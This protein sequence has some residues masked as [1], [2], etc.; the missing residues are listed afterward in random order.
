MDYLIKIVLF[1]FQ[2]ADSN[3]TS[4]DGIFVLRVLSKTK[5]DGYYFLIENQNW[6]RFSFYLTFFFFLIFSL[7]INHFFSFFMPATDFARRLCVKTMTFNFKLFK[8]E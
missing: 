8:I 7:E 2:L 4:V 6:R 5:N 3:L 1:R